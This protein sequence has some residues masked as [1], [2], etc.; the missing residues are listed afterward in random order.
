MSFPLCRE[1]SIGK[2]MQNNDGKQW[3]RNKEGQIDDVTGAG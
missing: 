2:F 1:K 3:W